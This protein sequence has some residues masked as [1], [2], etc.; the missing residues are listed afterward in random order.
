MEL[1]TKVSPMTPHCLIRWDDSPRRTLSIQP[2]RRS[3]Q[4]LLSRRLWIPLFITPPSTLLLRSFMIEWTCIMLLLQR[5][6]RWTRRPLLRTLWTHPISRILHSILLM[7]IM[8]NAP[9]CNLDDYTTFI[10]LVFFV[11]FLCSIIISLGCSVLCLLSIYWGI[12]LFF[13]FA[14]EI[15]LSSLWFCFYYSYYKLNFIFKM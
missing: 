1:P 14:D 9:N 7:L 3:S 8:L 13:L 4:N 15:P 10:F 5:I 12:E 11:C 6:Q 2:F